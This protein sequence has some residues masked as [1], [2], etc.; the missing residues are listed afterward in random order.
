MIARAYR[1]LIVRRRDAKLVE[2]DATHVTVIVLACVQ[3]TLLNLGGK[4]IANRT[5]QSRRLDNL[6]TCA[7]NIQN[8]LHTFLL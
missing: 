7:Y 6:G 1:K 8:T 2:E 5:R 4:A 3:D